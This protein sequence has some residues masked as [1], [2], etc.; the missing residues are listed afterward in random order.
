[1]HSARRSATSG[2]AE[3]D[4]LERDAY[5]SQLSDLLSSVT[6]RRHGGL[7]L[8]AGEA[9]VG[10]TALVNRFISITPENKRPGDPL[11]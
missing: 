11:V 1:M 4:L 9:G 2:E 3:R 6:S 10:K 7:V 5:L 8:L